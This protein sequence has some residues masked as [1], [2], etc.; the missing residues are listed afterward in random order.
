MFNTDDRSLSRRELLAALAR[1]GVAVPLAAAVPAFADQVPRSPAN[2]RVLG[3]SEIP[4]SNKAVLAP[5]DLKFLGYIRLAPE[6]GDLWY[7]DGTL[8]LRR[9]GGQSR[10]LSASSSTVAST[11]PISA[12]LKLGT[13]AREICSRIAS[14]P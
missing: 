2:V 3:P 8:A 7:S 13:P 14:G 4:S 11:K 1:T 6:A 9:V 10:F 5:K 12:A